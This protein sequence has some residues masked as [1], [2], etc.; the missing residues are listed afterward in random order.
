MDDL[1]NLFLLR[2][3]WRGAETVYDRLI[4]LAAPYDERWMAWGYERLGAIRQRRTGPDA[5]RECRRLAR[6][7]YH[8]LG[9]TEKAEEMDLLLASVG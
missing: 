7:L 8:R 2:K 5:A 4:D 3:Q 9:E 6:H 1:G